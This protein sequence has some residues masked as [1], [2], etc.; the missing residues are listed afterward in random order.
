MSA[1]F[2]PGIE[3]LLGA[4][5]R[6]IEKRKVGLLTHAAA[7]DSAGVSS[8]QLLADS[9]CCDLV[10]LFGP[11]HGLF[12]TAGAGKTVRTRRH[13]SLGITIH[14]LYGKHRKPTRLM[15]KGLDTVVIDLQDLSVRCYTYVSTLRLVLEA[16]AEHGCRVI[17]ADR[18][19][20]FVRTVDGPL[21]EPSCE[22]FVCLVAAPF[23]YG[24]TPG[25]TALW[26]KR[27]LGLTLDLKIARMRGYRR[28]TRPA[29]NWPRWVPPSPGIKSRESAR[30]Y[31]A[32]VL[33]EAFPAIDHGRG[34][35]LPFQLLSTP[36]VKG[37][38][39]C[40]RLASSRLP[41]VAFSPAHYAASTG[42]RSRKPA[43]GVRLTVT[44]VARFR[45]AKT[46]VTIMAALQEL[47]GKKRLWKHPGA[48][49]DF[50]DRLCGT[51]A[52]RLALLD[53]ESPESI[54][55][56]W[57]PGLAAFRK[58]RERCLLYRPGPA[59]DNRK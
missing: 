50:F 58:T 20:P 35:E 42:K 6:W 53:S 29:R 2:G 49:A 30:C 25:E 21:A 55:Q 14:S 27:S 38:A 26:I 17:V 3:S 32:T 7:V 36:W 12:A 18:P 28:Q 24:M 16:A 5:S 57:K 48:R 15:L 41:G 31:P 19:T 11:E 44:N 52:V 8:T 34:T 33:A 9:S 56:S 1:A 47:C 23:V 45:P 4:N 54:A 37:A 43:D 22:S 59:G 51:R 40:E 13:P 46:A 39:L 10:S